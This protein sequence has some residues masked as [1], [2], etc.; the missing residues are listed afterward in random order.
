M[1]CSG[2][3][4]ARAHVRAGVVKGWMRVAQYGELS[5]LPVIEG[6]RAAV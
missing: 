5:A 4:W 6:R 3:E 2:E 1:V